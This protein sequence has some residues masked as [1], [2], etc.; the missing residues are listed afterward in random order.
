VDDNAETPDTMPATFGY[1]KFLMSYESRTANPLPM[2][3]F[4][5]SAGT[6]IHGTEATLFVNRSKCVLVPASDK[7]AVQPLTFEKDK[8]MAQMNVPHW[9][10]WVEC[11]KTREKPTSGIETCVRSS[12]ACLLGNLAMRTKT[13]T[14]WDEKNRTVKQDNVKPYLK[15][16]Y[17]APWKLVV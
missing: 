1:P 16:R 8:D 6:T 3:G 13:L 10:N 14:D 15:A 2:F 12:T 7:S 17:R 5:E 9:K 4:G 11:V